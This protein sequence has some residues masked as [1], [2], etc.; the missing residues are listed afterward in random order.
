MFVNDEHFLKWR[1]FSEV[2]LKFQ[3]STFYNFWKN[4]TFE[5]IVQM[6]ECLYNSLKY[7]LLQSTDDKIAVR[8]NI[9]LWY[10]LKEF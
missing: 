4:I 6:C 5:Y 2:S 9:G 10:A 3:T 8:T 7:N 1:V